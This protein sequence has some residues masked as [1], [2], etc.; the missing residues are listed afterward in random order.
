[1][2]SAGAVRSK[3]SRSV[4]CALLL[5]LAGC[6]VAQ[7][8]VTP[9]G[10]TAALR[11]SLAMHVPMQADAFVDSIGVGTHMTYT[12]TNYYTQWPTVLSD[13]QSL[14]VRHIRDGFY[15]FAPGTP[16]LAEHQQLAAAGIKTDYVM[17]V[18][19]TTTP[20]MVA[21][22]GYHAGDMEAV[23]A[24]NECDLA[25]NCGTSAEQSLA[26]MLSFMPTVTAAGAA[27]AVPVYGPSLGYYGSY[28]QVGDL[29][30]E[31]TY[32]NL[33]V[34]FSGRNPG[35]N[36]WGELYVGGLAFG[37]IPFWQEMA[38]EDAPQTP[39]NITETGYIMVPQPQQYQIPPSVGASYMPR[40]LLLSFMKG[41]KRTYMYE[42]LDEWSSPGYGLIDSTMNPK[43]AFRAMQSLIA[44]LADKGSS[45]APG[46]LA[47]SLTGGDSTLQQVLFQKRDGSFWLV[48][49]LEQSSWDA[50]NLVETP[51]TPQD[52]TLALDSDHRIG[53]TGT[54][55]NTGNMNWTKSGNSTDAIQVSDAVTMVEILP[56]K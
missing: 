15:N 55:D 52:V 27:A 2:R 35:T 3:R 36:G 48:L 8:P 23:E 39:V 4:T 19:Q 47:Y 32:N 17:P 10:S 12:N 7:P 18:D 13:L 5:S 28:S 54:I 37:S 45:F 46:K 41:I 20:E 26:D 43:P 22:I 38:S 21:S 34:Y 1:S 42:L 14:G 51:V 6:A 11:S 25:G 30:S 49:W 56:G 53:K 44:N 40:T 31:M 24:P 33:H 29:S 9:R 50:V 16:Y